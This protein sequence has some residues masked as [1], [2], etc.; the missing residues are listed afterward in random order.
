MQIITAEVRTEFTEKKS[1]FISILTIVQS[2]EEAR[3]RI[4]TEWERYPDA[5]HIV[6][7]FRIGK[8][9]DLFG[10]SDD[11]EPHGTAG[12]PV[13][14]VLKGSGITN[15]LLMVVRYFGGTKLGT[16]G[17]VKA[18]TRAAKDVLS[19]CRTEELTEKISFSLEVPYQ[20]HDQVLKTL[21]EEG[22]GIEDEQF[23]TEV[24]VSGTLPAES[25]DDIRRRLQDLSSGRLDL[26]VSEDLQD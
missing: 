10:M 24:L 3:A 5:A 9:G 21:Q 16:G 12:R 25:A 14:E 22:A 11:G 8:S 7:A 20:L 13:F 4:R 2:Q 1:R 18:Y 15:V 17:L 26:K 23:S 6:Y 19:A